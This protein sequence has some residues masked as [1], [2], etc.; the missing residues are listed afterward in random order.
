[1]SRIKAKRHQT[2][3]HRPDFFRSELKINNILRR[4]EQVNDVKLL[5]F[6]KIYTITFLLRKPSMSLERCM[7]TSISHRS[8]SPFTFLLQTVILPEFDGRG[9]SSVRKF[10]SNQLPANTPN[11]D[12]RSVAACLQVKKYL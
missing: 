2:S 3:Y 8:E 7:I 11:E 6:S 10:E 9:L 4:N 5:G 12:R 1:M